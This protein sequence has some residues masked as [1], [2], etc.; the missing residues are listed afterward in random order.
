MEHNRIK[1]P[2]KNLWENGIKRLAY[3]GPKGFEIHAYFFF[4][5]LVF[6][7]LLND[8]LH[9]F[10]SGFPLCIPLTYT[11]VFMP[12]PHCFDYCGF[13]LNFGTKKYES[14]YSFIFPSICSY[15]FF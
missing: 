11:S 1:S 5:I 14:S 2:L 7:K 6:Y 8:P 9:E 4:Q 3:F 12:T 15:T 13:V 10:I